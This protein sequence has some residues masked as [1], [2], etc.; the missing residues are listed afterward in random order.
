MQQRI[1][2]TLTDDVIGAVIQDALGSIGYN[3][4]VPTGE[5]GPRPTTPHNQTAL[6]LSFKVCLV[7]REYY[8]NNRLPGFLLFKGESKDSFYYRVYYRYI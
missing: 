5:P 3:I 6:Y 4:N 1:I 7:T 8:N 2:K